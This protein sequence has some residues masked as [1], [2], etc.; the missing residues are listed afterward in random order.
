MTRQTTAIV[1]VGR[2]ASSAWGDDLLRPT[3]VVRFTENSVPGWQVHPL[4]G[5]TGVE[6]E[7]TPRGTSAAV[8]GKGS[9]AQE[10]VVLVAG[11]ILRDGPTLAAA[12][13][14]L[15]GYGEG[16]LQIPNEGCSDELVGLAVKAVQ[17]DCQLWVMPLDET[18]AL[19]EDG[20]VAQLQEWGV[21][22]E[23]RAD[24]SAAERK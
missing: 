7:G 17:Q 3:H 9:R 12:T 22:C 19:V 4:N 11:L 14:A 1:L 20:T 24:D 16:G 8:T 2:R 18:C 5:A 13:E 23:L 21:K 15:R 10:L 6:N